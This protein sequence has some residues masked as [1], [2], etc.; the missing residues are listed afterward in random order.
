MNVVKLI[1][2]EKQNWNNGLYIRLTFVLHV[3]ATRR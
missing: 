2:N 1:K 3:Q